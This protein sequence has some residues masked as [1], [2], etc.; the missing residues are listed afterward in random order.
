MAPT[1]T[2]EA[3]AEFVAAEAQHYPGFDMEALCNAARRAGY[4]PSEVDGVFRV[5][6]GDRRLSLIMAD[7]V[8]IYA[9]AL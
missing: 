9:E 6:V 2:D 4:A 1:P 8:D 5:R 3:W 7:G